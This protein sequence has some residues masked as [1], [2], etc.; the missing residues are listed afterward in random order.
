MEAKIRKDS[1]DGEM[2]PLSHPFSDP[3][4]VLIT[5]VTG[6]TG[7]SSYSSGLCLNLHL[8]SMVMIRLEG[9]TFFSEKEVYWK[10]NGPT[11]T[12]NLIISNLTSWL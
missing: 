9:R 8:G 3:S 11:R 1:G 2:G 5:P 10:N 6:V 12:N 4:S 7:F